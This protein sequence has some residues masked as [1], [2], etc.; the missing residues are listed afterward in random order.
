MDLILLLVHLLHLQ[1]LFIMQA[2]E[3]NYFALIAVTLKALPLVK[4][5][6]GHIVNLSSV[7]AHMPGI[8]CMSPYATSKHAVEVFSSSLRQEMMAWEVKVGTTTVT[9][10]CYYRSPSSPPPPAPVI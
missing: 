5:A 2:M 6:K 8:V 3:V 7:A 9:F 1:C 10:S 4:R